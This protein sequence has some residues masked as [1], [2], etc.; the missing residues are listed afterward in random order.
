[1]II[2]D[3][4]LLSRSMV[5][6]LKTEGH[7]CEVAGSMP[8]SSVKTA[9]N[10]YDCIIA[11]LTSYDGSSPEINKEIRNSYP[12]GGLLVVSGKESLSDKIDILKRGADDYLTKPFDMAELNAR[13][14]A[15]HRRISLLGMNEIAFNEI[16]LDTMA[17]QAF[18]K[19]RMMQLTRKEYD[20]LLLF[21]SNSNRIISRE[22]IVEHLWDDNAIFTDSLDFVYT[23]IRNLRKKILSMK[24][25]NYIKTVYGFGYKFS[26]P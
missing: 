10:S 6:Y 11:D 7:L 15:I 25:K 17:R 20:L 4:G 24:G 23:H 14:Y 18:V 8:E 26:D 22:S 3:D 21:M 19:G 12:E 9:G 2:E 13:L 16:R 1:M 5:D